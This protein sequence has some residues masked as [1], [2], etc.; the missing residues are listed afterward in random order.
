MDPQ[1]PKKAILM[2][3]IIISKILNMVPRYGPC[4]VSG[5]SLNLV[6][7]PGAWTWCLN[8]AFEHNPQ[9][10][11]LD[12]APKHGP[13]TQFLDVVPEYSFWM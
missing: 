9:T 5:Q 4:T 11:S 8:V 1:L 3:G 13:Q 2:A 7:K 6:L 12:V 10:Q